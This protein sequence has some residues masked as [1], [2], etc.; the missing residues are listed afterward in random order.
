MNTQLHVC[1]ERAGHTHEET[2]GTREHENQRDCLHG[3]LFCATE[4]D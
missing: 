4:P 1:D 2:V 3:F